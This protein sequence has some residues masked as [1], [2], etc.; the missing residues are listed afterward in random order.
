MLANENKRGLSHN[1]QRL[2]TFR[3]TIIYFASLPPIVCQPQPLFI[4][5]FTLPST[6]RRRPA[7]LRLIHRQS[8]KSKCLEEKESLP[9]ARPVLRQQRER[10]RSRTAQKPGCRSVIVHRAF[11]DCARIPNIKSCASTTIYTQGMSW[12]LSRSDSLVAWRYHSSGIA[13]GLLLRHVGTTYHCL[14]DHR[15][16]INIFLVSSSLVVVS[17]VS[18]R[19]IRKIKCAWVQKA[20]LNPFLAYDSLLGTIWAL[21]P[22]TLQPRSTVS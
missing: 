1:I 4:N 14:E 20:S 5:K 15:A 10:V 2:L 21:V 18:S 13:D 7:A 8:N 16:V 22:P 9:A 6:S 12:S 11:R 17:S 19:T 3:L